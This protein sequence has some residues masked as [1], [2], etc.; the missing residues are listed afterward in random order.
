MALINLV[1]SFEANCEKGTL[2]YLDEKAYTQLIEFYESEK[3]YDKAIDAAFFAM[4]QFN[5]RSDFYIAAARLLF[6]VNRID[7]TLKYLEEAENIAPYE[8]E[9]FLLKSKALARKGLFHEAFKSVDAVRPY[10]VNARDTEV[11][12]TEAFVYEHMKDYREMFD[13]LKQVLKLDTAHTEALDKMQYATELGRLNAENILFLKDLIDSDPYNYLAWYNLGLSYS[14]IGEYAKSI[15]AVEYSFIINPAFEEGYM[16]CADVCMQLRKYSRAASIYEDAIAAFGEDADLLVNLAEALFNNGEISKA[17]HCLYRALK[18][19][20]YNDET[21]FLLGE[22]F[23][24]N[25]KWYR[26]INAYHKAIDIE[27]ESENYYLGLARAYLQVENYNK[28]T[29]NFQMAV[30]LGPEQTHFWTEFVSFLIKLGL[31]DEAIQVLD[32]AEEYTY[33]ADLLICRG[34]VYYMSKK[35]SL[36]FNYIEEALEEEASVYPLIY[37]LAPELEVNKEVRSMVKYFL[38]S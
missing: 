25:K 16:E 34:V 7:E 20:P 26:A 1:S 37:K 11:L 2:V 6:A 9:I 19:D 8:H 18:H 15:D 4:S 13:I 30:S 33:G 24:A 36:G 35:K 10:V 5:Y 21:Y 17:K 28:A 23:S 29:Y 31:F 32:E 14:N 27:E 38:E 3:L 22:C 12:M